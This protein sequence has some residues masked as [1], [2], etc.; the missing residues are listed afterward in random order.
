MNTVVENYVLLSVP[1]RET[2]EAPK[3]TRVRVPCYNVIGST[4]AFSAGDVHISAAR[5]SD[6]RAGYY[7][8][9]DFFQFSSNPPLGGTWTIPSLAQPNMSPEAR[10]RMLGYEHLMQRIYTLVQEE[11]KKQGLILYK[12]EVEPDWSHEYDEKT[13]I[14]V[15]AEIQGT[16]DDRFT[17]WDS[18]A[19]R[20][21]DLEQLL[22][23]DEC[24]FLTRS[25]S[26]V[27][28]RRSRRAL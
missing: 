23:P 4:G 25:I 13:G 27:I 3:K 19:N 12:I 7:L 1:D 26:V 9:L 28:N 17:F 8:F 20:L 18:I 16:S 11:A 22:S 24:T 2:E 10:R 21:E 14:I 6:M 5:D 15:R